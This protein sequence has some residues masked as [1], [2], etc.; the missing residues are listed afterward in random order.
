MGRSS[1]GGF[2]LNSLLFRVTGKLI[3]TAYFYRYIR[4]ALQDNCCA[5]LVQTKNYR[6]ILAQNENGHGGS[7]GCITARTSLRDSAQVLAAPKESP[8]RLRRRLHE[9]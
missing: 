3:K 9:A 1:W 8:R 6:R 5:L 4:S 7:R 2:I